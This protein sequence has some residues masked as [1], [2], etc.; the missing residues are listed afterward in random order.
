[1]GYPVVRVNDTCRGYCD[2]RRSTV[3]GTFLAGDNPS[4]V[5]VNSRNLC[6][7]GAL[8]TADCGSKI[9]FNRGSSTV[10][11][12]GRGVIRS[13]DIGYCTVCGNS[14]GITSFS[15]NTRAGG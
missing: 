9:L 7:E 14:F 10:R 6:R 2:R 1:M 11:R 5:K 15:P 8:A 13:I 3:N 12:E 4:T